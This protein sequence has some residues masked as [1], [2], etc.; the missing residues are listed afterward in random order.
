MKNAMD[1][2]KVNQPANQLRIIL[3][4]DFKFISEN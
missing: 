1:A 4:H 2:Q 3:W